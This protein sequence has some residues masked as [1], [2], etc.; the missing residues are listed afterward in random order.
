MKKVTL[1]FAAV[2]ISVNIYS[3]IVYGTYNPSKNGFGVSAQITNRCGINPTFSYET[4][5]N[6]NVTFEGIEY[7]D[8]N[9]NKYG[10]GMSLKMADEM[11]EFNINAS[12]CYNESNSEVIKK[13]SFELGFPIN[14]KRFSVLIMCDPLNHDIKC[15]LGLKIK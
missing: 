6:A 2:M 12:I 7:G 5:K 9:V 11:G 10:L 4:S 13:I 15:G 3:Q 1:L 8:I 14:I